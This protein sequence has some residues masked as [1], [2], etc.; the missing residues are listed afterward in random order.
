MEL[1]LS[2][3]TMVSAKVIPHRSRLSRLREEKERWLKRPKRR[4]GEISSE[5]WF[6]LLVDGAHCVEHHGEPADCLQEVCFGS[7]PIKTQI[8]L[9]VPP[10]EIYPHHDEELTFPQ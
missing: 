8:D 9:R 4:K 10:V 5:I 6:A 3:T 1:S 2:T 7:K